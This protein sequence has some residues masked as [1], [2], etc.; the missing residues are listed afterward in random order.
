[1]THSIL[2]V[3][4]SLNRGGAERHVS[5]VFPHLQKKGFNIS[6]FIFSPKSGFSSYLEQKN[7]KIYT[8]FL[9]N[10]WLKLRKFRKLV[11][12]PLAVLQL[13]VLMIL[14]RFD[15]VHCYL[16]KSYI[17]GSM[18][19]ILSGRKVRVMSR[20]SLNDYQSK[21]PL[22]SKIEHFL[23]TKMT[24]ITANSQAVYA[25]L[26]EEQILQYLLDIL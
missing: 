2:I 13:T 1:M 11:L 15:I 8:P 4:D 10:F 21:Y 25:Q 19:A 20:R 7:I 18:A 6:V 26:I 16:T 5:V 12:L 14:K 24:K 23:H 9:I 17:L 22:L 3:I